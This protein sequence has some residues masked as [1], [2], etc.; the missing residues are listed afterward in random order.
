MSGISTRLC[1]LIVLGLLPVFSKGQSA[2]AKKKAVLASKIEQSAIFSQSFT[3]FTLLDPA[4]KEPIYSHNAD[5]YFTP[6]SNTKI[7]TLYTALQILGDSLPMI[8]YQK[9]ADSLII[10]GTG[11]PGFLNPYLPQD[12]KLWQLLV[13]S[14]Y[15]LF[16]T[17]P[18]F[19][20]TPFGPGWAWDDY[21][22]YFQAEKSAF[23]VYGNFVSFRWKENKI[24]SSPPYFDTLLVENKTDRD[25][26]SLSRKRTE[27]IFL[28]QPWLDSF[29]LK[30][31]PFI[32]SPELVAS[33]LSDT[34]KREVRYLPY[35]QL[36][37]GERLTFQQ[38][39]ADTLYQL[40]MHQS[41][42]FVAEQLLLMCSDKVFGIQNTDRILEYAEEQLFDFAPDELVWRDG[43]GLSRYNL[44]TPRTV[45]SVLQKLYKLVPEQRLFDLFPA[46]GQ[47]GTLEKWYGGKD[48]VSYIFA[49]TGTLSNKHCLSGYIRTK[50]NRILIFSFM[51]NN[52]IKG[53][54]NLKVEME[55]ILEWIRDQF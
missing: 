7:F 40:L 42:N 32:Y 4:K 18:N 26:P 13:D 49:K 39:T 54:N 30:E 6:A 33:L 8:H 46:G 36:S 48:T 34:L 12:S 27:N 22:Y 29:E 43:S 50:S 31:I 28:Y 21:N 41:D 44:F 23:P 5:K 25:M 9:Q 19:K 10:W 20:D 45:A 24:Y 53:P 51:H 1:F 47:A 15:Q 55:E 11:H 52:F 35:H 17:Y 37:S 16:F 14:S 38:T 3:G 2:L